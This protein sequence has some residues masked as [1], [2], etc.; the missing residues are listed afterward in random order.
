VVDVFFKDGFSG[1]WVGPGLERW[2]GD[3]TE[4]S[5]GLRQGYRTDIVTVGFGTIWRFS[6]HVYLNP[7]AAVHVPIGGDT[8]VEFTASTFDIGPTPEASVKLGIEF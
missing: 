8:K 1:F 2:N 4:K 3:V 7:W 6:R 5:S